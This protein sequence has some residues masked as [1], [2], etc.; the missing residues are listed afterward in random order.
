MPAIGRWGM[1]V[2]AYGASYA[3]AEG[4]LAA[5]FL[6]HLSARHVL[7]A[8]IVVLCLMVWSFGAASA[9]VALLFGG[10]FSRVATAF[11][12]HFLGGITGDTLGATNELIEV[13]FVLFM[14]LLLTWS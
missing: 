13:S 2:G 4:G 1:V 8:T 3:R 5:P 14:P 12:R 9:L 7:G 10:L 11:Y 6:A